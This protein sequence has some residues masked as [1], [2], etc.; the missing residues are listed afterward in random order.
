MW[1]IVHLLIIV[2]LS[3]RVLLRPRRDPASR[4]AWILFISALPYVGALAYLMLG[5]V[6]P[7][8]LAGRPGGPK[9][10]MAAGAVPYIQSAADAVGVLPG[11]SLATSISRSEERRVGEA[12][13]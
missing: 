7:D 5:E 2:G 1:L 9:R 6:R 13:R 8:R 3:V 4:I 10:P 12:W 11:F